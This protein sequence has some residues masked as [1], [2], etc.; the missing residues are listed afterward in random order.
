MRAFV[1]F[2]LPDPLEQLERA[3]V[4]TT[5]SHLGKADIDRIK[6][7]YPSS[8]ILEAYGELAEPLIDRCVANGSESHTLALV[9]DALLPKLM[10]GEIR[11]NQAEGTVEEALA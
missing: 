8:G 5:V 9:R 10:S 2:S 7:V 1:Y 3:K 6:F 4:G 11:F